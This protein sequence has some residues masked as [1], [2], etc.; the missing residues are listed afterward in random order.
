MDFI[1]ENTESKYNPAFWLAFNDEE[2]NIK[3]DIGTSIDTFVQ[4][5][6]SKFLLGQEP[7]S[8]WDSYVNTVKEMGVEELLGAYSSAYERVN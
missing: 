3:Q 4:S 1:I 7:L 8:N 6:I 5:M 2:Q